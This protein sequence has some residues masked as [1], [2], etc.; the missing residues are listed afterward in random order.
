MKERID[1]LG[2]D[3]IAT[4]WQSAS[5]PLD[6]NPEYHQ[7]FSSPAHLDAFYPGDD[8]VDWVGL[9]TYLFDDT[10]RAHQWAPSCGVPPTSAPEAVYDDVLELAGVHGKP[11]MIAEAAPAGYRTAQLDASCVHRN[12]RVALGGASELTA[13]FDAYVDF[14]AE[15]ADQ[16]RAAAYINSD[17]EA[18]TQFRCAPGGS[19]GSAGCTDGY[20]G[21]SR[22]QDDPT[23]LA[24]YR[25][26][27]AAMMSDGGTGTPATRET[28]AGRSRSPGQWPPASGRSRPG[29]LGRG[30]S[31][32]RRRGRARSRSSR[33]AAR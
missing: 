25:T 3:R 9:S 29:A 7:D 4:V 2:A 15:N 19:A 31:G 30:T 28:R 32:W 18:N 16:I 6:G 8:V 23:V 1:T 20:W 12:E 21:N 26:R 33:A 5:Y 17:W 10:Y 22:V 13:W 14:V 27:L 11:V 24:L